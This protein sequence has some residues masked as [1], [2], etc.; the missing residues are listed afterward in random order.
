VPAP[1]DV[2]RP[3]TVVGKGTPASCTDLAFKAAVEAG[4]IITFECGKE[5]FTLIL[6][7]EK[8][9]SR[10]TVIDGG[11]RITLSGGLETRLLAIRSG[12]DQQGP[13]LT[14]QNLTMTEGLA[15]E[16]DAG[17]AA[18]YRR[19]GRLLVIDCDFSGH[20]SGREGPGVAGGAIASM[21]GGD[22]TIVR[23]TFTNNVASNGG[24]LGSH[25]ASL[26]LIDTT[27]TENEATGG[28][29]QAGRGGHGGAVFMTGARG[30]LS[31]CDSRFARNRAS[32]SGG[33]LYRRG[34]GQARVT[35]DRSTFDENYAVPEGRAGLGGGAHLEGAVV[36]LTR[37]T[38]SNNTSTSAGGLHLSAQSHITELAMTNVTIA[39]NRAI[40]G[41]GGGLSLG[42]GVK[43]SLLNVTIAGNEA[44]PLMGGGAGVITQ[45]ADAKL[46]NSI[47]ASN[48]F[49][50][51]RGPNNCSGK[52]LSGGGNVQFPVGAPGS[53]GA[54]ALCA[55]DVVVGDP[56]LDELGDNGGPTLTVA[57]PP[58]SSAVGIANACPPT[59]QRGEP[60]KMPCTAGA[61]ERP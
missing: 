2:S 61:F 49:T 45:A 53:D 21:G 19:G 8:V 59:D 11:G 60:R 12:D 50:E 15:T 34:E 3:T 10:D 7:T 1:V 4:G 35:I 40:A 33:G 47:V 13:T 20:R 17:G 54:G 46:T 43:A 51:E 57:V 41:G 56:D 16:A 27:L 9:V 22:T 52:L 38:V 39:G 30:V 26:V 25:D 24:A 42:A 32:A 18:I 28:D 48:R 58:D 29:I 36:E 23:S 14:L 44:S 55:D 31:I 5:P 6:T 37:S